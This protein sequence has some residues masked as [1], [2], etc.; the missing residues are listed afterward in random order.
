MRSRI[1]LRLTMYEQVLTALGY[2]GTQ[3]V[4]CRSKE[5]CTMHS[6]HFIYGYMA[7]HIW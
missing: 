2:Q 6:T 7:S 3:L 4:E 5:G 1:D